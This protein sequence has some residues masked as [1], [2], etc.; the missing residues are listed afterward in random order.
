[1]RRETISL[2]VHSALLCMRR[3]A[4]CMSSP[5]YDCGVVWVLWMWTLPPGV[6]IDAAKL[7]Y[8]HRCQNMERLA[9]GPRRGKAILIS[10]K[11]CRPA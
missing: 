11:P 1:M 2:Q 7:C 3:E 4:S 8:R 9:D 10:A 6:S 5:E